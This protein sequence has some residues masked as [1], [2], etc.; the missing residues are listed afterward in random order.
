MIQW[1]CTGNSNQERHVA[2]LPS[3]D[4][5]ITNVHSGLFLTTASTS[6][7]APVLLQTDTNS[8]LQQWAI[9]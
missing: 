2:P 5:T 8:T 6:D 7:G 9:D 1:S 3:G 4:Y